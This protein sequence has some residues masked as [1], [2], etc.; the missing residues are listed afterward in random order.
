MSLL[1]ASVV[2]G[3]QWNAGLTASLSGVPVVRGTSIQV[4]EPGWTKGYYSSTYGQKRVDRLPD[5]GYEM[6]FE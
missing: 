4:Y 3:F 6:R 1:L 5:G 2:L